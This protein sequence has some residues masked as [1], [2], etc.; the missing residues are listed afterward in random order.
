MRKLFSLLIT[1][2]LLLSSCT[3]GEKSEIWYVIAP[4]GAYVGALQ[5]KTDTLVVARLPLK[6][7]THY[8]ADLRQRGME[9]DQL[10]ALQHL[11]GQKGS[12]YLRGSASEWEEFAL[13]GKI[14]DFIER[15][16]SLSKSVSTATLDALVAVKTESR[17]VRQALKT[18]EKNVENLHY[19]DTEEFIDP[20]FGSDALKRYLSSW[21]YQALKA[22]GFKLPKEEY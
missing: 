22:A 20:S 11:F 3:Q 6:I 14:E 1:V 18:L 21:F 13:T 15:S 7:L 19:Y 16:E 2:V 5:K 12:Y 10:G 9:S 17:A 4:S 8:Q